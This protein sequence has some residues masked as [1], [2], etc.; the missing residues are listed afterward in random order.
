MIE[1]NNFTITFASF[2]IL[3]FPIFSLLCLILLLVVVV[4]AFN[5]REQFVRENLSALGK[6]HAKIVDRK[7]LCQRC[8]LTARHSVCLKSFR[9]VTQHLKA[10][11]QSL[12]SRRETFLRSAAAALRKILRSPLTASVCV[13]VFLSCRVSLYGGKRWKNFQLCFGFAGGIII[14][15]LYFIKVNLCTRK[16]LYWFSVS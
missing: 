12:I 14:Q 15:D 10:P 11:W 3:Y 6:W 8:L 13:L 7:V 1:I 4:K 9:S 5:G 16:I 2:S